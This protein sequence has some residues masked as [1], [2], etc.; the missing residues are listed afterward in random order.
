MTLPLQQRTWPGGTHSPRIAEAD[1]VCQFDSLE[2]PD[3]AKRMCGPVSAAMV[4]SHRGLLGPQWRI[5]GSLAPLAR[6]VLEAHV[7]GATDVLRRRYRAHGHDLDVTVRRV[8]ASADCVDGALERRPDDRVERGDQDRFTPAF[9]MA[10]GYDHRFS[11]ALFG[12]FGVEAELR[13]LDVEGLAAG[14][15]RGEIDFFL[16]SVRGAL[17]EGSHVVVVDGYHDGVFTVVDPSDPVYRAAVRFYP[18]DTM[19][20]LFNGF[21]TAVL[22]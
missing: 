5:D 19:S 16:A 22:S 2:V 1:F 13:R 18:V 10:G 14:F 21:G 4:L 7:D 3:L 6:L 17:Y 12:R 8:A 20:Y 11:A 9:T 15:E